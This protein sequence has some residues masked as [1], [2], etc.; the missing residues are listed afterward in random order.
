MEAEI[1]KTTTQYT[2]DEIEEIMLKHDIP[3]GRINNIAQV[4]ADPQILHRG[5]VVEA[6]HPHCGPYK[7][8]GNPLHFSSI[9]V[10]ANRPAPMHGQHN[11]EV[12]AR[13]FGM[14]KTQVEDFL[15]Q[16]KVNVAA[17]KKKKDDDE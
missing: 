13:F 1:E 11:Y 12:F 8:A 6:Q 2:V 15:A 4:S 16:Q 9:D 17:S 3:F 7:M 10:V 5:M 14:D